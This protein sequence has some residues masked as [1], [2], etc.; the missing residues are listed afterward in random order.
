MKYKIFTFLFLLTILSS[1]KEYLDVNNDPFVPQ[2]GPPHLYLSQVIYAMAEGP[3][4]DYR[5]VSRY[6]QHLQFTAVNDNYDRHGRRALGGGLAVAQIHRNHYWSI[7]SNLNQIELQSGRRGFGQYKGITMAIRAYSWQ[8]ATD[9]FGEMPYDQAWDNTRTKFDYNTQKD[10]YANVNKLCDDAIAELSKTSGTIDPNL[11]RAETIYGGNTQ[12]WIKFVYAIKARLANHI[13]NKRSYNPAQVI[14]F[15]DK[16]MAVNAE[17]AVVRFST[18]T[19]DISDRFSFMGPTRANFAAY[20][21]G[22]TL[23]NLMNGTNFN[24]V[25]DPRLPLF[26]NAAP[27]GT[28]RT[29]AAAAGLPA[30]S[31]IVNFPQIYGKYIF[32]D[33]EPYPLVTFSELQFIKAEAALKA[34]NNALAYQAFTAGIRANMQKVGITEANIT[35]FLG[36]A[37]P[38]TP[39]TLE[40]KHIMSQ[41][42]IAM[43]GQ[44]EAWADLRRYSYNTNIFMGYTLPANLAPENSGKPVQRCLPPS[45]SEEDWNSAAFRAI[46]GYDIDYHT[47]PLWF[48]TTEE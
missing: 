3:M 13:S 36:T 33:I 39:A 17:D 9:Q 11:A 35:A 45:F 14:E 34:G 1:C 24:N 29:L 16:A 37:I 48:T 28:F 8:I 6:T 12:L 26:L 42:Y 15:V 23:V 21:Q 5:N 47:K 44:I 18:I 19:T 27:D 7:G 43:Y 31:T 2:E 38:Q 41:K 22:R 30:G 4:F 32:R 46:G 10:I 25:T 20:R 40:I